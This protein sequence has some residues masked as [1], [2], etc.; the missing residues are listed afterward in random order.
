MI[1]A[2]NNNRPSNVIEWEMFVYDII[3]KNVNYS[4]SI[5]KYNKIF[6]NFPCNANLYACIYLNIWNI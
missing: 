4:Y 6:I 1:D 3:D 5:Q 2:K